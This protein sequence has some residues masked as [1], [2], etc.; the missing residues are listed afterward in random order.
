MYE[1]PYSTHRYFVQPVS[2]KIHVKNLLLRRFLGFLNQVEK[3]PKKLPRALLAL[4][5]FDTRST[6]GSNLRNIMNLT[7]KH[8]IEDLEVDEIKNIIYAPINPE[9]I[10]KIDMVKEI[11]DAK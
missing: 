10:W 1:L 6:T 2:G 7:D 4:I 11:V 9:D 3:S 8:S 5:K